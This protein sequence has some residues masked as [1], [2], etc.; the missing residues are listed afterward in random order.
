[1]RPRLSLLA[2]ATVLASIVVVLV[3]CALPGASSPPNLAGDLGGKAE[4]CALA[5]GMIAGGLLGFIAN[6]AFG[7]IAIGVMTAGIVW[8]GHC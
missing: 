1:M 2:P 8:L 6:P 5:V 3:Q 7:S 4:H